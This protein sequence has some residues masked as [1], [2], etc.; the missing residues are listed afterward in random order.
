MSSLDK[1]TREAT[2]VALASMFGEAQDSSHELLK[3]LQRL[4]NAGVVKRLIPR[5]VDFSPLVRLHSIGALR[6]MSV[7][8]GLDVCEYMTE[9]DV[10]TPLM[11]TMSDAVLELRQTNTTTTME[12]MEQ[13]LGLLSHLCESCFPA[14]AH[15][16][17]DDTLLAIYDVVFSESYSK[18]SLSISASNLLII[19]TDCNAHFCLKMVNT[20]SFMQRVTSLVE[21][22]S[23]LPHVRLNL[24]GSLLNVPGSTQDEAFLKLVIPILVEII[25]VDT[26]AL[27]I[28]AQQVSGMWENAM[29][30]TG[31]AV[32]IDGD[33]K[34]KEQIKQE[35]KDQGIAAVARKEWK[36]SMH[37]LK[38]CMEVFANLMTLPDED[39]QEEGYASDDNDDDDVMDDQEM[40][41]G[42]E[43]KLE[44]NPLFKEYE[45]SFS[46]ILNQVHI[47]LQSTAST[48]PDLCN[49]VVEDISILRIR[50]CTCLAN[51][52][53]VLPSEVFDHI[54]DTCNSLFQVYSAWKVASTTCAQQF[55][56]AADST[57]DVEAAVY[58][59]KENNQQHNS[60]I[61]LGRQLYG[62]FSAVCLIS[63]YLMYV[64]EFLSY[65]Y[66]ISKL[67]VDFWS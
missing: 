66:T 21:D 25:H 50:A 14:V 34:M 51:A 48:A 29:R 55:A 64:K 63:L 54:S 15:T 5:L 10:I 3:K 40:E 67:F 65:I 8:G 4:I 37:T 19:L 9:Q 11:K 47:L 18:T 23:T 44:N 43:F 26:S 12:I 7:S 35:K 30:A 56:N 49:E 59:K 57:N 20:P 33:D 17:G 52:I 61:C 31:P 45:K 38:L 41:M 60:W 42:V 62:P 24:I 53:Q 13:S 22:N 6:N 39:E 46:S 32:E 1:S 2:C 16:V 28:Q 58:V 36:A 27:A